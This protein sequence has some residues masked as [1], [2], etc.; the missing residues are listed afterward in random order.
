MF[1]L[2][3]IPKYVHA[4]FCERAERHVI[5]AQR[6]LENG[7]RIVYMQKSC[8]YAAFT[9]KESVSKACTQGASVLTFRKDAAAYILWERLLFVCERFWKSTGCYQ[10]R[11]SWQWQ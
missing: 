3:K 7:L 2:V 5:H 10:I 11:Q 6:G 9:F 1:V 4:I 8:L